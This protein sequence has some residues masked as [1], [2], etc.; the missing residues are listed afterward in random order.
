MYK[1]VWLAGLI[2]ALFATGAF[3][4]SSVTLYGII[5]GGVT[6]VNNTGGAHTYMFDDGVAY[7]NRVGFKGTEDLGGGYKTVFTL[8]N[9]FRLGTGQ[10]KQGGAMFGRQAYVGIGNDWGTLTFGNQY[11]FAFDITSSYN[12]SAFASGYGVHLGDADRQSGDRLANSVKFVSNSFYG[13]TVGG[14]Y[15]FSN[16]AGNFHDGSA[17][18]LGTT[19]TNGNFAA[20]GNF[21]RLNTPRGL[22]AVDPYA[23]FG[24][25][26]ML[27]QTVANVDPATGARNDLYD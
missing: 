27:G 17:W 24:I 23:Q 9:G 6:Y 11:D 19:Y 13:F 15:S 22:A 16:T 26:S 10:L 21:T 3:A 20:G 14:M 18:S 4:Q 1:R 7:G 8:E 5:D 2:P 12:V 25:T